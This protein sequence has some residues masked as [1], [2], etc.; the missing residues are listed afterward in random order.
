MSI[1]TLLNAGSTPLVKKFI[2]NGDAYDVEPYPLIRNVS[3]VEKTYRTTAELRDILIAAILDL[4]E[5][6]LL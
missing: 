6:F 3:S 2:K 5:S 4:K 1:V